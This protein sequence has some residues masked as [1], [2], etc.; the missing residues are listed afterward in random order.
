VTVPCEVASATV[1][2]DGAPL[3]L[4]S[5]RDLAERRRRNERVEFLSTHDALTGLGNRGA[6]DEAVTRLETDGPWPVGVL[7]VDV[8]G[9]KVVN[10]ALGHLAG[11]ALLKRM[12]Q[13]LR[14][15]FR[16]TDLLAR[17]G[18]DEFCVLAAAQDAR[19]VDL[20]QQRLERAGAVHREQ[21]PQPA[22]WFSVGNAVAAQ[23]Q[24]LREAIALADERMYAMKARHRAVQP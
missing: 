24:T 9:L 11:D 18:G 6:F 22:L 20:L 16:G 14:D 2:V 3:T 7:M 1:E 4:H 10:D 17:L 8:D 13:L 23:G 19:A 5:L 15:T 21:V 12:A